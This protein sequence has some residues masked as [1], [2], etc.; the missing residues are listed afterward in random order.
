MKLNIIKTFNL[1]QFNTVDGN[2]DLDE[3]H[4]RKLMNNIKEHGF[5]PQF[6]IRVNENMQIIDGQHRVE[7]VRRLHQKGIKIPVYYYR[8]PGT[9]LKDCIKSNELQKGWGHIDYVKAYA[10][11][12][13]CDNKEHYCT[14]LDLFMKYKNAISLSLLSKICMKS[15][16]GGDINKFVDS[17]RF[18]MVRDYDEVIYICDY[19][20]E[21]KEPLKNMQ[22]HTAYCQAVIWAITN[23]KINAE[24]LKYQIKKYYDKCDKIRN[25][26]DALRQLSYV[27]HYNDRRAVKLKPTQNFYSI[28]DDEQT[29]VREERRER[30]KERKRAW[31]QKKLE[32]A[33]KN[34][35][36]KNSL[37][38]TSDS[39]SD[40]TEDDSCIH[41]V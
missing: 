27:Y 22:H 37:V 10:S 11:D 17:G 14:L 8:Q 19:L 16:N 5:D 2:R 20:S 30:A 36:M 7:A 6:Y 31:R 12:D 21:I 35:A 33:Q 9:S 40:G 4:V 26:E 3:T 1:N 23:K 28:Y 41:P 32:E 25:I 13:T 34:R 29:S 15:I 24:A 39:T 18:K 38:D